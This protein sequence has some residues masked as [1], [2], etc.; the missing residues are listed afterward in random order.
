MTSPTSSPDLDGVPDSSTVAGLPGT[1]LVRWD[2]RKKRSAS[3]PL[4]QEV[5]QLDYL[6]A[7]YALQGLKEAT[8]R[9]YAEKNIEHTDALEIQQEAEER[10]RASR[11]KPKRYRR[12]KIATQH[13][14]APDSQA[15]VS[16]WLQESLDQEKGEM[17]VEIGDA[18]IYEDEEGIQGAFWGWDDSNEHPHDR[19]TELGQ[20]GPVDEEMD[21]MAVLGE[22]REKGMGKVRGI[23][24]R[25]QLVA[26]DEEEGVHDVRQDQWEWETISNVSAPNSLFDEDINSAKE[27]LKEVKK[28]TTAIW[29]EMR[30]IRVQE[31]EY[32]RQLADMQN[33]HPELRGYVAFHRSTKRKIDITFDGTYEGRAPPK[34]IKAGVP[35]RHKKLVHEWHLTC[36][37][38][39]KAHSKL[40]DFPSPVAWDCAYHE[41][42]YLTQPHPRN[43][44]ARSLRACEHN[45]RDACDLLTKRQLKKYLAMFHPDRFSSV[46][47]DKREE[48]KVMANEVFVVLSELWEEKIDRNYFLNSFMGK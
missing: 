45:I 4:G 6:A 26:R 9:L 42:C 21:R 8:R 35:Y 41:V 2:G 23:R 31:N 24:A 17:A 39:L 40:E 28:T 11:Q 7:Y 47:E 25:Q 38:V 37:K 27:S 22:N 48:W 29:E 19:G 10:L 32:I 44:A 18:K 20:G 13:R 43:E 5:A 3:Q 34:R 16:A 1:S 14:D 33:Q 36:K 46:C 30:T 12:V 15:E